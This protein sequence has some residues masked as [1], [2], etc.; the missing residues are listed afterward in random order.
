MNFFHQ[1]FKT[2]KKQSNIQHISE[3]QITDIFW[4]KLNAPHKIKKNQLKS[5]ALLH[6]QK[7]LLWNSL[8]NERS[9]IEC[10]R[11]YNKIWLGFCPKNSLIDQKSSL[12]FSP[13]ENNEQNQIFFIEHQ[14]EIIL[15]INTNDSA[16]SIKNKNLD[17]ALLY[18]NELQKTSSDHAWVFFAN[19][20]TLVEKL[21][22]IQNWN[23]ELKTPKTS[24]KKITTTNVKPTIDFNNFIYK[25]SMHIG[26]LAFCL[27]TLFASNAYEKN[28]YIKIMQKDQETWLKQTLPNLGFII[29]FDKQLEQA[30]QKS[31]SINTKK[32]LSSLDDLM[33]NLN[34]YEIYSVGWDANGFTIHTNELH[35]KTIKEKINALQ[36][37][38][39]SLSVKIIPTKNNPND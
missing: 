33:K 34:T 9:I 15:F 37:N 22:T 6:A 10:N 38:D 35:E 17:E 27:A 39:S 29:D 30:L 1:F 32:R 12:Y 31:I 7:N 23:A 24:N 4:L 8:N 5:W 2:S 14:H 3:Q 18:V 21:N 16:W 36:K 19:N 26:T 28:N 11:F 20:K 13:Q 25:Y